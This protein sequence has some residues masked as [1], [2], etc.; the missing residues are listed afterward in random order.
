[1]GLAQDTYR[2][3]EKA[4]RMMPD[5]FHGMADWISDFL[6]CVQ[7][8]DTERTALVELAARLAVEELSRALD[9]QPNGGTS[10]T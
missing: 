9:D 10:P 5:V 4:R 7:A 6:R 8:T 2:H 3:I 1:M